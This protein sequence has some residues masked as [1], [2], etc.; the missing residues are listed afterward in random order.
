MQ[1]SVIIPARN[2]AANLGACLASL[3]AQGEEFFQ[4]GRDWEIVVVDDGST[5]E[6]AAI[7]QSFS[8]VTLL[9]APPLPK[10]WTGKA[11]AV[12]AAAQQAQGE[13]LLFADADTV[14]EP[15]NLRRALHEA[16]HYHA[17]MLSYS[18]RQ[19]VQGLWMRAVMPLVF[20]E[21]AAAYPPQ[22]VSDP[23][24]PIA[25]ANGQFLLV[26][27]GPYFKLGGHKAVSDRLL[28]DVELA[29]KFKRTGNGLRFRY[30]PDAV[31]ARMYRSF[32]QMVEG[33]TKNLA[34]LFDNTLMLACW[35][36]LDLL[37]LI[38]LPLLAT[39]LRP[40]LWRAALVLLWFRVLWRQFG[41]A[42]RSNFPAA[43]CLLSILGL[44]IFVWMLWNSWFR[45][46][47]I[48]QVSWKGR[49]Y[50]FR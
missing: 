25:A 29:R 46:N 41:L 11:N 15:G 49:S 18:P 14:H 47:V 37:L 39:Q 32:A 28:E 33:W 31:S 21:L 19:I 45:R 12:W 48:R 36:A 34:L 20:A 17:A 35:R 26:A 1:L 42:R 16:E 38:G 40:P 44:P 13:W 22:K 30:A 4:L 8:E 9:K 6:T 3:V 24:L 2:E 10:D 43:D 27:R 50:K 7:A 5:D 23:A